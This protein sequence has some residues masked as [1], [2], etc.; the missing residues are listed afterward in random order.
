MF[1]SL[2]KKTDTA[3]AKAAPTSQAEK[4]QAG[5]AQD[6]SAKDDTA[7]RAG[8][9]QQAPS[10]PQPAKT[11]PPIARAGKTRKAP[12]AASDGVPVCDGMAGP[13]KRKPP[14]PATPDAPSPAR[15]RST[16][17]ASVA[18]NKGPS[19]KLPLTVARIN[20]A[21]EYI[22]L[23]E[24]GKALEL[25]EEAERA[26]PPHRDLY[27]LQGECYFM[28]ENWRASLAAWYRASSMTQR[29]DTKMIE[30]IRRKVM[31]C[32]AQ[33]ALEELHKGDRVA[34]AEHMAQAVE[35]VDYSVYLK[36]RRDMVDPIVAYARD[37]LETQGARA[38]EVPAK[39]LNIIIC[40]DVIKISPVHS[41]KHLY[42][43]L[44]ASLAALDPNI[45]VT[46]VASYERQISWNAGFE[47]YYRPDNITVLRDF[48]D[49][50]VPED[51][52]AR[53]DVRYFESFGLRG[54]IRTCESI[55]AM[56]PDM[57]LYGGGRS[58]Y[59]ANESL[60][61]RHILYKYVPTG[62]FFVQSNNDVDEVAD[63]IIA[64][65]RHPLN[66][67][68]GEALVRYSPYPPFPG[69]QAAV[70][71][72][73]MAALPDDRKRIVTAWV[74]VR[75]DKTLH[76][77]ENGEVDR[78]LDLLER[79]PD[80]DWHLIGADDP[81]KL[82][83]HHKR[84]ADLRRRGRIVVHPVLDYDEFYHI[85]S[86]AA[87]FFQP[88]GFTGGGGG[89]SIARN[90]DVP[91]ICFAH[92]DVAPMQPRDYVF[93]EEDLDAGLEAAHAVL[94]DH[95]ERS[96]LVNRQ[97][98][99]LERRRSNAPGQFYE[100]MQEGVAHF[101]ARMEA[102]AGPPDPAPAETPAGKSAAKPPVSRAKRT[103]AVASPDDGSGDDG[104][105]GGAKAG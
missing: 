66:G 94:T 63:V 34:A 64:R 81:A 40:L 78:I 96:K 35:A 20:L 36:V 70:V 77:Y 15:Q 16:A 27:R 30:R 53:I 95:R 43:S 75:L 105:D 62:F 93:V 88:P 14:A 10:G 52:R 42:L 5:A 11:K 82:L 84:F 102:P 55:L 69:L 31:R 26:G 72:E 45:T 101:T 51:L 56:Q 60:L 23:E 104:A 59:H 25:L 24:V 46:L 33:L 58:G 4:T 19:E 41:H 98:T 12:P 103:P 90:N 49:E 79:M 67:A 3:S 8:K 29:G 99:L 68:P 61:V 73:S 38:R 87:L 74:G 2:F 89:A 47:D 37:V 17:S 7:A 21:R 28:T 44:A 39:P 80:A 57:I 50:K 71:P 92:S 13:S 48:I 6:I 91:I 97:W 9:P 32:N 22:K 1:S 65:G 18:T 83:A 54:V 76:G 86:S 100:A 85:A